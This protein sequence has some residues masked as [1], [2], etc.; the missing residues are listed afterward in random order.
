MAARNTQWCSVQPYPKGLLS[1]YPLQIV[2]THRESPPV[3]TCSCKGPGRGLTSE[4]E[5]AYGSTHSGLLR[6]V[7]RPVIE[8]TGLV[9]RAMVEFN[10]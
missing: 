10:P 1:R 6:I 4:M 3:R 8:V 5:V 9:A 7:S 2:R